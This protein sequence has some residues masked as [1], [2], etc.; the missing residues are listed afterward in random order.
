[1]K[2]G[3]KI[4]TMIYGDCAF[5]YLFNWEQLNKVELYGFSSQRTNP[6]EYSPVGVWRLKTLKN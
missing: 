3:Y 1:M 5:A 4:N 6:K 2:A